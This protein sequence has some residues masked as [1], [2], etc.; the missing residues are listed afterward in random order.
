MHIRKKLNEE[1]PVVEAHT[2]VDPWT[3]MILPANCVM[4]HE[5]PLKRA[6]AFVDPTQHSGRFCF[7]S[8]CA[9]QKA[10]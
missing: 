1:L 10:W 8:G 3:V 6:A 9:S 4:P 2:V 5:W 7:T